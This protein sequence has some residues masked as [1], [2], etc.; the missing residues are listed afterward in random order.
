MRLSGA[1][2]YLLG[3]LALAVGCAGAEGF[4][5]TPAGTDGAA[6]AAGS[7]G[8]VEGTGGDP[9]PGGSAVTGTGGDVGTGGDG[10][11]GASIDA[12][13]GHAAADDDAGGDGDDET[14]GLLTFENHCLRT[15]WAATASLYASQASNVIDGDPATMWQTFAPQSG[16]EL[17]QIDMGGLVRV[18]QIVLDNSAGNGSDYPRGYA[19]LGSADGIEFALTAVGP[20]AGPA[21]AVTTIN[22]TPI[23]A[24]ALRVLQTGSDATRWWSVH[25]LRMD[26]Q[27]AEAAPEGAID[28][29]DPSHWTVTAS[30]SI[31]GSGP[32]NAID[33]DYTTRWTSGAHQQGNEWFL[34]DMGAPGPIA[35]VWLITRQ[36][37]NNYPALF[38]LELSTDGLQYQLSAAGMGQSVLKIKLGAPTTARYVRIKQ[39]GQTAVQG[40]AWWSIDELALRP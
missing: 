25:E 19:V 21:G 2:R 18:N 24:R 38:V 37:A 17:L 15:R 32:G 30:S 6:S 27:P 16:H 22:F 35:E 34:I 11:G 4:G 20:V 14:A 39:V 8:F 23:V 5:G 33:G 13:D 28:P 3:L 7:G 26:C 12:A 36:N 40:G 31:G 1:L 10:S 29:F 9:G